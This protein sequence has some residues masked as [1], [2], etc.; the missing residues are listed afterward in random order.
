MNKDS[1]TN[2]TV[3]S[4]DKYKINYLVGC[5]E[6][7][8]NK[9]KC[10]KLTETIHNKFKDFHRYWTDLRTYSHYRPKMKINHIRRPCNVWHSNY[11]CCERN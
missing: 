8:A 3:T 6:N 1:I 11:N 10:P 7:Q 5:L 4:K 2:P 9:G